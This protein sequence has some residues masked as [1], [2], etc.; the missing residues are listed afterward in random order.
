MHRPTDVYRDQQTEGLEKAPRDTAGARGA[1]KAA[2][3]WAGE[4]RHRRHGC[5]KRGGKAPI[6]TPPVTAWSAAPLSAL[7]SVWQGKA[8]GEQLPS[9]AQQQH[10]SRRAGTAGEGK[11][12]SR[13]PPALRQALLPLAGFKEP[14]PT[15]P[16]PR[17]PEA[18]RGSAR[19]RQQV[20][21]A[22][23]FLGGEGTMVV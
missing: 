13:V 14:Q 19:L 3:G 12:A 1:G 7:K 20:N 5:L 22:K 11:G 17:L 15:S 21:P 10:R 2:R 4:Q 9:P 16:L 18:G 6:H 23:P 8:R